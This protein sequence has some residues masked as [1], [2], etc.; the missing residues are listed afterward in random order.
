M[1]LRDLF[2]TGILPSP[3]SLPPSQ[4]I[5]AW[6]A[7]QAQQA[8]AFGWAQSQGLTQQAQAELNGPSIHAKAT[9]LL[10]LRLAGLDSQFHIAPDEF[11]TC[12]VSN[13]TVYIFF[14]INDKAGHIEEDTALFPSDKLITQFRLIR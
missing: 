2:P 3:P 14:V 6:D 12:H 7:Q 13:S 10:K 4:V 11:L 1:S 8:Q 9:H 5:A